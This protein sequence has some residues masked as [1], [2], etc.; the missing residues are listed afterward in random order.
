MVL[1]EYC[2]LTRKVDK[3]GLNPVDTT[4]ANPIIMEAGKMSL[5]NDAWS[6]ISPACASGEHGPHA[7]AWTLQPCNYV[8]AL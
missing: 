5:E 3:N 2:K 6:E 7:D 4:V 8:K 1:F